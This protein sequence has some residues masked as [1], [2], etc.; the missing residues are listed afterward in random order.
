MDAGD[1]NLFRYEALEEALDTGY[2]PIRVAQPIS[3]LIIA[4]FATVF[5]ALMICF[6]TYGELEKKAVVIGITQP[7]R[8][9]LAIVAPNGGV[10]V[11]RF[12]EEGSTVRAGQPLFEISTARQNNTGELTNLIAQQLRARKTSLE[13]ERRNRRIQDEEK[14]AALN[15]KLRNLSLEEVELAG[16]IE[17]AVRRRDLGQ[18]SVDQ[19]RS[20]REVNFASAAQLQEKLVRDNYL[21]R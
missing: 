16:A 13:A 11:Q 20:L 5:A 8:G 1:R 2:G 21:G 18:K 12:V 10:L 6:V 9:S 19:Y 3:N 15:D 17:L 4:L 14:R 7:S